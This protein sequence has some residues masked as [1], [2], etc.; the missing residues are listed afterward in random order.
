MTALQA[1]YSAVDEACACEMCRTDVF[2]RTRSHV[3]L[4]QYEAGDKLFL[5]VGKANRVEERVKAYNTHIPCGLTSLKSLCLDSEKK[6]YDVE[7]ILLNKLCDESFALPVGGDW[8]QVPKS[9]VGEVEAWALQFGWL[10]LF[11]TRPARK[12]KRLGASIRSAALDRIDARNEA[13]KAVRSQQKG[14]V[15]VYGGTLRG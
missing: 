5:K 13:T 2:G 15:S 12:R 10:Y 11:Y 6:A 8:F 4:C 14:R 7:Q 9:M 1:D 3:Y